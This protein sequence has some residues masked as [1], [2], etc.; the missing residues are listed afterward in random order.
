MPAARP[1][2]EK[3][4]VFVSAWNG[5]ATEACKKAGISNAYATDLLKRPEI[6]EAIQTAFGTNLTEWDIYPLE[7]KH[8]D[9][10]ALK[11]QAAHNE[12]NSASGLSGDD[13]TQVDFKDLHAR[14]EWHY[15]HFR[16]H[17]AQRVKYG[18]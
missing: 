14:Q 12:M 3:Q 15:K 13:L 9:Q 7:L 10:F 4:Q 18:I 8:W 1:L 16:E 17:N 11:H 2:T 5:N 6:R